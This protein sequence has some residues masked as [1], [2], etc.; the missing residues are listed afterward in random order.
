LRVNLNNLNAIF[1]KVNQVATVANVIEPKYK[2]TVIKTLVSAISYITNSSQIDGGGDVGPSRRLT[3][4]RSLSQVT[5][6]IR[7]DPEIITN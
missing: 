3:I 2:A 4:A 6:M 5:N 7:G 1:S